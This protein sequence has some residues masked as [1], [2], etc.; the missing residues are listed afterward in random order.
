M[1]VLELG[2]LGLVAP[3]VVILSLLIQKY[4]DILTFKLNVERRSFS[5]KRA[6]K[7]DEVICG[8]KSI[9]FNA[10]EGWT[11]K[12]ISRIRFSENWRNLK[13]FLLRGTV[14]NMMGIVPTLTA[15]LIF[16]IYNNTSNKKLSVAQTYSILILFNMLSY[17]IMSLIFFF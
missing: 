14:N 7:V 3:A 10:W 9:K 6:S 12:M 8:A 15:V 2:V 16:S 1:I 17:P 11:N 5:D 4:L 13:I